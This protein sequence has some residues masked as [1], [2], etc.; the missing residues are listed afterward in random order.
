MKNNKILLLLAGIFVF[1][2]ITYLSLPSSNKINE[3]SMTKTTEVVTQK[4]KLASYKVE[5]NSILVTE[6]E[7]M[8]D[9]DI[10]LTK[11]LISLVLE[12]AGEVS[13]LDDMYFSNDKIYLIFDSAIENDLVK[14]AITK[15]VF[16]KFGFED[17]IFMLVK[18]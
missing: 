16:E 8:P 18:N 5:N 10:N 13:K 3:I 6:V 7:L 1:L 4:I 9:S 2:L 15:I 11:Q 12:E 17:I 14:D